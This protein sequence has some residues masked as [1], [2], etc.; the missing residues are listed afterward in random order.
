MKIRRATKKD[1]TEIRGLI[2][3]YPN[4]LMQEDIPQPEKFFVAEEDGK[5]VGCCALDIYSQRIAEVRS[6][7]VLKKFWGQ[8]IGKKLVN[9]C[10]KKAQAKKI[11]EVFAITSRASFFERLGFAT[12][13]QEKTALFKKLR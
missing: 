12:F 4:Q 11:H 5:I 9:A 1:W 7:A 13:Q 6:L 8:G 10:L 2:A 3:L